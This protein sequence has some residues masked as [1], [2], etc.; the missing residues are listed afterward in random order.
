MK[1]D[2]D[3]SRHQ[4]QVF[5]SVLGGGARCWG[6]RTLNQP[7]ALVLTHSGTGLYA[8]VRCPKCPGGLFGGPPARSAA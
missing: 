6:C 8:V 2:A 1:L 5:Y 3:T 4:G 7:D